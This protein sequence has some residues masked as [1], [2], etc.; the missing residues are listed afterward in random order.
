MSDDSSGWV[1]FDVLH[2]GG[3]HV[4]FVR[5]AAGDSRPLRVRVGGAEAVEEICAATTGGFGHGE[6]QWFKECDVDL[7]NPG[8]TKLSFRAKGF[9]PHIAKIRLDP[10][11]G[12]RDIEGYP[13]PQTYNGEHD[14]RKHTPMD[15]EKV[16]AEE[17]LRKIHDKTPV[18]FRGHIYGGDG[19]C[20]RMG[21]FRSQIP[22]ICLLRSSLTKPEDILPGAKYK[23]EML[24]A[25]CRE[26][27]R[28]G[29]D[30][31]TKSDRWRLVAIP[32]GERRWE[33]RSLRFL[34]PM[35]EVIYRHG[36]LQPSAHAQLPTCSGLKMRCSASR[37]STDKLM[38]L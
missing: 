22:Y 34:G 27:D 12:R 17:K 20:C 29:K 11:N 38:V 10:Q 24:N 4:L 14:N 21:S 37:S 16:F 25:R 6:L 8:I 36:V 3:K 19:R 5:Y 30:L 13:Q 7:G 31:S 23:Q 33:V 15:R 1:E 18:S 9:M 28:V 35:G 26:Q 32:R 2:G